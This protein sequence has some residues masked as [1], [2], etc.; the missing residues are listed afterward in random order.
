MKKIMLVFTFMSSLFLA[1]CMADMEVSPESYQN[2]D[3][4][5]KLNTEDYASLPENPFISVT[6]MAVSTFSA[7]VD[8]A[9][10]SNVR[11][12]LNDSYLPHVDAVR[13]EELINYFDYDLDQ[14]TGDEVISITTEVSDAPWNTEHQLLMIGLKTE[15]IEFQDTP[16]NNLV[17]LLDVSGSMNNADKLPL[18]QSAIKML[19]NQLRPSDRISIVVYA[20]AAG[21]VLDGADGNQK[22][23]I[24]EAIDSLSAGGSTAGGAGINLA[25]QV[26]LDHYIVGGNNRVI[27]GTDG[28]F[29]VGVSSNQNLEELIIEKRETG[30]F[31]SVLGFGTGNLQDSKMETLADKGNGVYYYI[32]SILEAK[33]VFVEELGASLITVAKDVKLQVEFNPLNVKG[34]RLIGYENRMLDYEDFD[35]DEKDAGDMGAGH[36]VVVFYEII[37]AGSEEEIDSREFEIPEDLKYDGTN[38]SDEIMNLSIRYKDPNHDTSELIEEVVYISALQNTPSETYVFASSVVEFGL[39]L[40]DSDYKYNSSFDSIITRATNSLGLDENGYRAE[41]L[42]LVEVAKLLSD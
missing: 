19:V 7:D 13:I 39:L 22:D 29:N 3:L 18:L 6:D 15:E 35:N 12:M 17:F 34:Y 30:I 28:D 37:P 41:F 38:Y 26:A 27:L 2:Y 14:P 4:N 9:S 33:K 1:G 5:L 25:Y 36:E 8:T 20:G 40:R 16:G 24:I 11:R 23:E 42:T 10:Y 21:L 31:L 32:D